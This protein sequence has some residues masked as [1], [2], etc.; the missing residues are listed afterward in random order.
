MSW[1][2]CLKNTSSELGYL[3][4]EQNRL[5]TI[6]LTRMEKTKSTCNAASGI[7]TSWITSQTLNLT[8]PHFERAPAEDFHL[9]RNT[10]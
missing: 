6:Q 1:N 8:I 2:L 4:R 5:R 9:R 7:M 10:S 3:F